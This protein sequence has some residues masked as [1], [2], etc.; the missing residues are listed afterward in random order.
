M[1]TG[2]VQ[3]AQDEQGVLLC[4]SLTRE[5]P[6]PLLTGVA[7]LAAVSAAGQPPA[8]QCLLFRE[9]EMYQVSWGGNPDKPAEY[10]GGQHPVAPR[11]SFERWV[12]NR[13]G[14]CREWPQDT[15]LKL[16]QLRSFLLEQSS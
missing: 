10:S 12:E 5:C 1:I 2:W 3:Q 9:E 16:L 6:Q 7:G 14:Y 13:I 4:Q 11:N 8:L 15:R